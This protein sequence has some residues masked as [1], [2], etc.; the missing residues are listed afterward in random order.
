LLPV[1]HMTLRSRSAQHLADLVGRVFSRLAAM[2]VGFIMS[3]VGL[4][5]TVTI[6]MLPVGLLLGLLGV[7]IFVG[8]LFAREDPTEQRHG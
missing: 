7:A 5:L 3:A 4:G 6:V 8:G 2:I 1:V